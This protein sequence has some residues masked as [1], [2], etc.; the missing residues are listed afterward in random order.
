MELI[1]HS[2]SQQIMQTARGIIKRTGHSTLQAEFTIRRVIY[3][4]SVVSPTPLPSVSHRGDRA[5]LH[6]K[7]TEDLNGSFTYQA[8]FEAR[9]LSI[10]IAN[11]VSITGRLNEHI[12]PPVGNNGDGSWSESGITDYEAVESGDEGEG[13]HTFLFHGASMFILYR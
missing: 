12:D 8:V 13:E 6:Y 1:M 2:E 5:T 10:N 3:V 7:A 4:Y 11:G 9:A